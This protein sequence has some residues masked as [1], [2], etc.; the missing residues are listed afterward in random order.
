MNS[1]FFYIF[2]PTHMVQNVKCLVALVYT[3]EYYKYTLTIVI[4]KNITLPLS[5]EPDHVYDNCSML[6]TYYVS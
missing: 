2:E 6:I 4:H 5:I 1:I 3:C